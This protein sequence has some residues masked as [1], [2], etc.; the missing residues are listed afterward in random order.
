MSTTLPPFADNPPLR[1]SQKLVENW[2]LKQVANPDRP[3]M[4]KKKWSKSANN[5]LLRNLDLNWLR[6]VDRKLEVLQRESTEKLLEV[7]RKRA[8]GG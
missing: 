2:I 4:M 1:P 5:E 6:N 7:K 8:M 3:K